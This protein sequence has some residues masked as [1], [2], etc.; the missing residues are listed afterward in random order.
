MGPVTVFTRECSLGRALAVRSRGPKTAPPIRL[1][2]FNHSHMRITEIVGTNIDLTNAIKTYVNDKLEPVAKL[3]TKFEPC[4]V[5]ADVGKTSNHHAKGDVFHAEFNLNIPGVL[6]RA[7]AVKDD[8]YA[9][10]DVA[11]GELRRQVTD[12]KEKLRDAD[13]VQ[14]DTTIVEHEEHW[15]EPELEDEE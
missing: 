2:I 3:C 4:D 6:L 7:E 13:R 9:A 5:A 12:Y 15:E 11:A 1:A 14:V 10:I 8:L